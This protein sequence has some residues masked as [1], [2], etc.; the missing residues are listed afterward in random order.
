MRARGRLPAQPFTDAEAEGKASAVI[1]VLEARNVA[2][3]AD[4]RARILA[5]TDL[6]VLD[7]WVRRAVSVSR[8]AE[9]LE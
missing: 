8:A 9:L 2:L 4:E 6:A 7:T 1:G 5:C 3:S